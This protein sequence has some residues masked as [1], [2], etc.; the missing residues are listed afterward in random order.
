VT[1]TPAPAA[2]APLVE[3]RGKRIFDVVLVLLAA[4]VTLVLLFLSATMV[5]LVDGKPVLYRQERI[6][7]AGKPFRLYKL[8]TMV[9][10]SDRTAFPDATMLTK[11]GASLRRTSLD[12]LP[13]LLNVLRGDMSW[14]GPRPTLPYQV[15][16]Y[17]AQ[18]RG[19]LAV[20]PGLTGLA[21]VRG[22]NGMLWADR[23]LL[24]LEYIR[25]QSLGVDVR[26][27]FSSVRVVISGSGSQGH[28]L[29]DPLSR[30]ADPS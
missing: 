18:Q 6:G 21:Q 26:I 28:P 17:D 10:G 19:R 1:G 24:D 12:E 29:D 25:K 15:E 11:T 20:R 30:Q 5:R 4:P 22:R 27:L 2:P 8:R 23:I 14:V 3:Y 7:R 16:R 9:A 13:Q